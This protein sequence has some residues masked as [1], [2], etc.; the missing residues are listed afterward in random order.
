MSERSSGL[1]YTFTVVTYA[2]FWMIEMRVMSMRQVGNR[3]WLLLVGLVASWASGFVVA[4]GRPIEA[5]YGQY[6]G[7]ASSNISRQSNNNVMI[8]RDL[9]VTIGP[10]AKKGFFIGWTTVSHKSSGINRKDY[11]INFR[12]SDRD[13]IYASAMKT[14]VFGGQV[15]LDPMQGDPFVWARIKGDTLTVHMLLITE[16]GGYEMQI[17]NRTLN[18]QGLLLEYR[19]LRTGEQLRQ[20]RTQLVR[21]AG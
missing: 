14:N 21:V 10:T 13:N 2:V 12:S 8:K 9:S 1:C 18:A 16:D 15:S 3:R 19:L 20:I 5:F 4:D 17:Y 7:H 11:Q 6:I